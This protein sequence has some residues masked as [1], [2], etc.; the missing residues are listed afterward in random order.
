MIFS[1]LR[2]FHLNLS[3]Q[4]CI[5]YFKRSLTAVTNVSL[6]F[7]HAWFISIQL[8]SNTSLSL[9]SIHWRFVNLSLLGDSMSLSIMMLAI[10]QREWISTALSSDQPSKK[11][12][13]FLAI[14]PSVY[15][16]VNDCHLGAGVSVPGLSGVVSVVPCPCV[17]PCTRVQHLCHQV[18]L[19]IYLIML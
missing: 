14:E 11:K 5:V 15:Y 17:P 1:W 13:F 3:C 4:Y 2:V 8:Y 9:S 10:L 7:N 19:S 12:M 18:T 6:I 16:L